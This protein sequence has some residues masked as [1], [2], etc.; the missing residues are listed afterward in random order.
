[1]VE[2]KA[3]LQQQ[4]SLHHSPGESGVARVSANRAQHEGVVVGELREHLVGQ[5]LAGFEVVGRTEG[6]GR[7]LNVECASE[8]HLESLDRF[9]GD[10]RPNA[11][12]GNHTEVQRAHVSPL[13]LDYFDGFHDSSINCLRHTLKNLI[14]HPAI[15]RQHAQRFAT[16]ALPRNLHSRDIN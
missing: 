6:V 4:P 11:V 5:H 3:Q 2:L 14:V 9:R 13:E 10:F 7:R 16:G 8:S 1:M 15:H 12:A